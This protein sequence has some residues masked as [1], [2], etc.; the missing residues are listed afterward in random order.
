MSLILQRGG[1]AE[2]NAGSISSGGGTS[3][4][5]PAY[6][7]PKD[8]L[9]DRLHENIV[10]HLTY[11]HQV[12]N[13]RG[14]CVRVCPGKLVSLSIMHC[15]LWSR[16]WEKKSLRRFIPFRLSAGDKR[17]GTSE[18]KGL[19]GDK[20]RKKPISEECFVKVAPTCC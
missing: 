3:I 5:L 11:T 16:D 1:A 8:Q 15:H 6:Y 10:P 14:V 13:K 7:L 4:C 18:G 2:N 12:I 9:T 17:R 20:K 19:G